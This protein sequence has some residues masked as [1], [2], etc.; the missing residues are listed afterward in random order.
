MRNI[1]ASTLE[2][3]RIRRGE[4]GTTEHDGLTGAF[5]IVGPTGRHLRILS[6]G[7]GPDAEGWEH[8]SVSTE[9]RIPNWIEMCFVKNLFWREDECA[10]QYHP[11]KSEYVNHHPNCLH[12]WKPINAV[13]PTPPSIFVG[14]KEGEVA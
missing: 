3:G 10:V 11:A 12:I 14:P 5:E 2:Q 8:V 13:M 4:Y 7:T 6:S 1:V 9:R